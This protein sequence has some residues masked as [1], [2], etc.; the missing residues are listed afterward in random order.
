M[1]SKGEV[2]AIQ[3]LLNSHALRIDL[4]PSGD[5]SEHIEEDGILGPNTII[6]L[7]QYGLLVGSVDA[8]SVEVRTREIAR[9]LSIGHPLEL[10]TWALL[11][12]CR[13]TPYK[14][15]GQ[16]TD[17]HWGCD[18]S[19]LIT[20]G[21]RLGYGTN[22]IKGYDSCARDL[23]LTMLVSTNDLSLGNIVLYSNGSHSMVYVGYGVVCGMV[24]GDS[25]TTSEEIARIQNARCEIRPIE[26]REIWKFGQ[27]N[28]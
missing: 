20:D 6:D 19:G 18:C 1:L 15:G 8:E 11:N 3:R 10:S 2:I 16:L 12:W 25:T 9:R 26:Y 4:Y 28:L 23:P 14:Y 27:L 5:T 13:R 24:R 17:G 7:Y 21:I 22:A